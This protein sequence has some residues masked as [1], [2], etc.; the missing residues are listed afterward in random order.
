V[1]HLSIHLIRCM[2][3]VST[4]SHTCRTP[5]YSSL[6]MVASTHFSVVILMGNWPLT[7]SGYFQPL[8]LGGDKSA[9]NII[10]HVSVP[11]ASKWENGTATIGS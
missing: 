6:S 4:I 3:T 1:P 5:L 7:L 10:P 9:I 8:V 2:F 11:R